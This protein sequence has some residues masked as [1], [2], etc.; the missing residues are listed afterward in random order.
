[1]DG[2]I[3]AMI[4]N[5]Y[6]CEEVI[7]YVLYQ[8]L[9]SKML[10]VVCPSYQLLTAL[11][12]Y[13]S[14]QDNWPI[15]ITFNLRTSE[16]IQLSVHSAIS[17]TALT[18]LQRTVF[19]IVLSSNTI[20]KVQGNY[21]LIDCFLGPPRQAR[22]QK[23]QSCESFLSFLSWLEFSNLDISTVIRLVWVHTNYL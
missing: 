11:L 22:D 8:L 2:P 15:N 9:A 16:K 21:L 3:G 17:L 6:I 19:K 4:P 10:M 12:V 13:V 18:S 23:T 7:L 20:K 1:M 5:W 14:R